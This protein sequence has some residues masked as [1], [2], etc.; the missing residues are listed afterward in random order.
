LRRG[1]LLRRFLA[2]NFVTHFVTLN[3]MPERMRAK[4]P[5]SVPARTGSAHASEEERAPTLQIIPAG[6][7]RAFSFNRFGAFPWR[8]VQRGS[9]VSKSLIADCRVPSSLVVRR[10][11]FRVV[12]NRADASHYFRAKFSRH[13]S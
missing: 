7:L 6:P 3:L 10:A 12:T 1:A 13:N 2:E 4:S 9:H 8:A 5:L 11:A